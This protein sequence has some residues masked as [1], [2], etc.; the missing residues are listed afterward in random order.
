MEIIERT[1]IH[2][3]NNP[4]GLRFNTFT[5]AW[6]SVGNSKISQICDCQCVL[7]RMEGG[8]MRHLN[9]ARRLAAEWKRKICIEN[10]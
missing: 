4:Y 10:C 3:V 5:F 2:S 6:A 9:V 8:M 7:V 1:G